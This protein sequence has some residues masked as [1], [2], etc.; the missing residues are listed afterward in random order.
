MLVRVIAVLLIAG[1]PA[2]AEVEVRPPDDARLA[3]EAETFGRA[4]REAMAE[5]APGDVAVLAQVLAGAPGPLAPEGAWSCRTLK[6]GGNL[7][8]VVYGNFRCRIEASDR[9]SWTIVK[10]TGSQ[11]LLGEV[12]PGEELN[13]Y[14]GV[15]FVDGGPATDYEGLP[16]LDQSPVEPGQTVAQVGFLEQMGPDRARLMLPSPLLESAYDILYLTR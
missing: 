8:L 16:S 12:W 14:L 3:A 6:L 2:V 15:G 1:L 10:E 13:L 4:V 7:P 9:E 11:R 5:G